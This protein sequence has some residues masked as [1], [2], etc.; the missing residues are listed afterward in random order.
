MGASITSV[1]K[2]DGLDHNFFKRSMAVQQ[3][4]PCNLEKQTMPML[5]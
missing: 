4:T 5:L 1:H 3:G 2:A